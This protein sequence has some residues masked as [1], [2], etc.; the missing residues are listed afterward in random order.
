[1]SACKSRKQY[2]A[3]YE[4]R[5]GCDECWNL[6]FTKH[7]GLVTACKSTI[8]VFKD[9]ALVKT[10]GAVFAKQLKRFLAETEGANPPA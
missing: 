1:M 6:Y 9:A 5:C 4:P 3:V 2:K 7:P 8:R 10:K